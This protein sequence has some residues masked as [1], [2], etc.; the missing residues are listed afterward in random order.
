LI[1]VD[2][3][4]S[5]FFQTRTVLSLEHEASRRPDGENFTQSTESVCPLY[6]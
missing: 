2:S 3:P 6:L 4:R 5:E 1:S